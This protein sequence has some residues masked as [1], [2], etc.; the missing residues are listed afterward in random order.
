MH[1][2]RKLLRRSISMKGVTLIELM[3]VLVI[4]AT[5]L[6]LAA[7]SFREMI[8]DNRMITNVN[9]LR[10]MLNKA[11]SEALAR[12]APVMLCPTTNGTACVAAADAW[13]GG[14][15]A[16][17]NADGSDAPD[18]DDPLQELI[19]WEARQTNNLSI[20]FDGGNRIEFH[21]RGSA[22][23]SA[24]TFVFCDNRGANK[25]RALMLS[26]IGSVSSAVDTN[27]DGIVNDLAGN[28]VSC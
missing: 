4:L 8:R 20:R 16:F 28:N 17:L 25:A 15:M 11:R 2:S 10:A 24:G 14:Y 22:L 6:T 7:P 1:T 12:R 13:S 23:G 26:P 3:I 5:A 18:P 27:S 21:P 19:Q 9:A